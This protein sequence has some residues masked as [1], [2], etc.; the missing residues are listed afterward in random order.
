MVN[1]YLEDS[2][3]QSLIEILQEKFYSTTNLKELSKINQIYMELKY[4]SETWLSD[5][6]KK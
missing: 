2:T 4:E 1:V 5:V 3:Y 6:M